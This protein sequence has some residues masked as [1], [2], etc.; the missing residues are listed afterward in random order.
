MPAVLRVVFI[1]SE[2]LDE[3]GGE[4]FGGAA[5]GFAGEEGAKNGVSGDAGVEGSGEA[6][7]GGFAA[8]S[9]EQ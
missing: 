4:F 3:E 2:E 5:E 9:G 8:E 1:A 7:A 6:E